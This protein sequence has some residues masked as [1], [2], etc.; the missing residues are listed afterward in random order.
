MGEFQNEEKGDKGELR[1]C[2]WQRVDG[3]DDVINRPWNP[4]C[5]ILLGL[6]IGTVLSG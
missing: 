3:C 6:S 1:V 5:Q 2:H 4:R